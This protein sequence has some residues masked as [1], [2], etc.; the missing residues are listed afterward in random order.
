M[1]GVE[2]R[3]VTPDGEQVP[4]DGETQGELQAAGP[5]ITN[6]YYN[7]ERSA[8]AM[9]EDGWCRTGDVA[10]MLPEGYLKL[11]DRTKDVIK[12][13]GEW[14]SSVELENEIMAHPAVAEAAVIA[15]AHLKWAERPLACVVLRDGAEATRDEILAFLD[16]RVAKWWI[17][18]DVVFIDEV[19]KTSVGKFSK[20][21]L[22]EQF[23]DYELPGVAD[24]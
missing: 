15:V 7:D 11:V 22:R 19:P 1:L 20:K 8:E 21:T 4:W 14:I 3:V 10:V 2:L 18:D 23:A 9:T 24:A 12:T 6:G 16:G 17:P 13:G 5:W